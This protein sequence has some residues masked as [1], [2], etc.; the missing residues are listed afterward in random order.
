MTIPKSVRD[1]L[2]MPDVKSNESEQSTENIQ[3]NEDERQYRP[4]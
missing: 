3:D 1:L 2:Y 4:F